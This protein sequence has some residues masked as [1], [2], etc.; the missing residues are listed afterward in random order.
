[1]CCCIN[2]SPIPLISIQ[3]GTHSACM[4]TQKELQSA[5][6][7]FY[8]QV[9]RVLRQ[10]ALLEREHPG[11][12]IT[13]FCKTKFHLIVVVL[14]P[15]DIFWCSFHFCLPLVEILSPSYSG[16]CQHLLLATMFAL[17]FCYQPVDLVLV[18]KCGILEILSTLT[19]NSCALMNQSWFAASASGSMLLSGAV[20][21]ACTRLLQILTVAAR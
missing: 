7:T 12:L 9:V 21:L 16:S 17:N 20:R 8:Q 13:L 4:D 10:R 11:L 1:M 2:Y 3:S 5:A 15:N 18:I 19:N 14:L 6:H